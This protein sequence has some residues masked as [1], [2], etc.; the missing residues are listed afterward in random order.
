MSCGHALWLHDEII[1]IAKGE[2]S[3]YDFCHSVWLKL[4]RHF[5]D[6]GHPWRCLHLSDFSYISDRSWQWGLTMNRY[7]PEASFKPFKPSIHLRHIMLFRTFHGLSQL[8]Q[9]CLQTMK[10]PKQ[11][12]VSQMYGRFQLKDASGV[13]LFVVGPHIHD[14]S[15][16]YEKSER[17]N[18]L[19]GCPWSWKCLNNLLVAPQILLLFPPKYLIKPLFD[20]VIVRFKPDSLSH[21]CIWLGFAS[22]DMDRESGFN[23]TLPHPK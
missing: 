14:L 1:Q 4:L 9:E 16:M 7:T 12:D 11:Y 19:Q 20:A 8:L 21:T 18:H 13:Y 2:W 17:S 5:H 6:Q 15:E 3:I 22:L 23:L 10:C